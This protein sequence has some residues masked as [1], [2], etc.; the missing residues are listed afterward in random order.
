MGKNKKKRERKINV[1][2]AREG[3]R[4]EIFL[5][6]LQELF[7]PE[8]KITLNYPDDKGG[9]SNVIL[10]RALKSFYSKNYAWFDEDG[11]LDA[12]HRKIL[13]QR[14]YISFPKNVK[15]NELQTYNKRMYNP[16]VIVSTPLSVE[17]VLIRL[18]DHNLPSFLEPIRSKENFEENKN[19]MKSSVKGFMGDLS[20]IE[21]YRLHLTKDLILKKAQE[22]EELRIL[23]SIFGIK[24]YKGPKE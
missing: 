2:I 6:Y 1:F 13:E 21:Y 3:D 8:K 24:I 22:I 5:D 17:G 7:D 23:L 10:D 18:F 16:I 9:N 15:D 20:D 4:E 11:E 19:R 14:W 12:E